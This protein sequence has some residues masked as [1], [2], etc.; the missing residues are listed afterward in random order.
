V[1]VPARR[2]VDD[3]G[4][5]PSRG[6]GNTPALV[7]P[8]RLLSPRIV[9]FWAV[10]V[11]YA[12][13]TVGVLYAG[14]LSP[15]H[16][17]AA[18]FNLD[19]RDRYPGLYPWLNT[20]VVLGQRAP[21][22]VVALPWFAWR[23][24]R[25]RTPRPLVLLGVALLVLNLTVGA[26]KLIVGRIGP[27]STDNVHKIF[28]GGDIFPSGHVANSVVLY[29]VIAMV[30]VQYRR[31][32]IAAAVF[33]CVTVGLSTVF[34]DT[35]WFTDVV[36]GWCAGGLVLLSLPTIMPYVDRLLDWSLERLRRSTRVPTAE[37]L[38]ERDDAPRRPV[39]IAD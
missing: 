21:A 26:V 20:Y 27:L 1:A 39:T 4:P 16:I 28:A 17:D 32:A 3:A 24:W 34:L 29:G 14:P 13:I 8:A 6:I 22:T 30:A 36:A 7:V 35:H 11:V 5:R 12:L 19:L 9:T 31:V 37:P 18:L 15:L 10:L 33:I 2:A 38:P 25:D 23:A